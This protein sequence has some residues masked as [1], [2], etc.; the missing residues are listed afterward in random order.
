MWDLQN[1]F[2][3]HARE[4]NRFLRRR[5]HPPET[6]AD[7]TQDTFVRAMT[8]AVPSSCENPRA[9]LHQVAR[10]LSIDLARRER[11][12]EFVHV[13]DDDFL[14]IADA[15]P[16]PEHIV[17]DRQ[18]LAIID[19]AIREL[20]EKTR[21]AFEMHR[22]GEQTLCEVAAE[23]QLSRTRTWTLIRDAY[24]HLRSRLADEAS[25]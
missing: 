10:N 9:Y 17:Y 4:I 7:L 21:R 23:L 1:L 12:V 15:S 22:I 6:A 18:R 5:G 25:K 14:G 19:A 8:A 11:R 13:A 16:S 20:P 24:R 3:R 2:V